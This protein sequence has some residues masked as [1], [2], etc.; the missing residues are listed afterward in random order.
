MRYSLLGGGKRIRPVLTLATAEAVGE[1]PGRVLPLAAGIELIHTYSLIHDDLPAMDDDE[2]RRGQPTCHVR[3]GEDVAILAGDGSARRAIPGACWPR[4]MRSSRR[5][6][7]RGWWA[8][9]TWTWRA[10]PPS[11]RTTSAI[12]TS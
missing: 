6:G 9:S 4:S 10:R 5:R 12:C 2:L 7:C 1:D 3:Y 8:G 11:T